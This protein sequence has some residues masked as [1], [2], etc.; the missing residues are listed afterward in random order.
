MTKEEIIKKIKESNN[1]PSIMVDKN[2]NLKPIVIK[3]FDETKSKIKFYEFNHLTIDFQEWIEKQRD[4]AALDSIHVNDIF[5]CYSSNDLDVLIKD[6]AFYQ[7]KNIEESTAI[8]KAV[9]NNYDE[10]T[11]YIPKCQ[12]T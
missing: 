11:I 4:K 12:K 5:S 8:A 9:M 1:K 3:E 10:L 6:L 2:G 7:K